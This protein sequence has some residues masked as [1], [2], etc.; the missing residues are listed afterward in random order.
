VDFFSDTLPLAMVLDLYY[1]YKYVLF[2][3]YLY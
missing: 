1:L 2:F 3:I